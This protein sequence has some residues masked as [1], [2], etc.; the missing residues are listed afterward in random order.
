MCN[1][2]IS[3]C[4]LILQVS[5]AANRNNIPVV[6]A[7]GP[8]TTEAGNS[9]TSTAQCQTQTAATATGQGLSPFVHKAGSAAV[10]R[11]FLQSMQAS[12]AST[13]SQGT[14]SQPQQPLVIPNSAGFPPRSLHAFIPA[15]PQT[16][17]PQKPNSA[18]PGTHKH[19]VGVGRLWDLGWV[20]T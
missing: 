15:L 10:S 12:K 11:N 4:S 1:T 2:T 14:Q 18:T 8:P 19:Q 16:S 9:S 7:A 17:V 20:Y 5:A 3:L 13:S 6:T